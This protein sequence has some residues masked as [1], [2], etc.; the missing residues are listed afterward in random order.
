MTWGINDVDGVVFPHTCGGCRRDSDAT[1][2]LLLHP[3]HRCCTFVHFT[4]FV[5]DAGIE[6][7][8]LGRGG[9]ARVDVSHDPDVSDL[10]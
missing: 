4:D 9:F 8:A 6:K 2:L 1:F 5:V 7:N 10:D 3:V